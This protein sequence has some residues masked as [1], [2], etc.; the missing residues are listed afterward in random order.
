MRNVLK[1]CKIFSNNDKNQFTVT[2]VQPYLNR[3]YFQFNNAHD[4]ST[5][6]N[7][8]A[9]LGSLFTCGSILAYRKERNI[10]CKLIC[11]IVKCH[12]K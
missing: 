9:L 4:C 1:Y 6:L 12:R 8:K 3:K 2:G 7:V 10:I 11:Y 5:I